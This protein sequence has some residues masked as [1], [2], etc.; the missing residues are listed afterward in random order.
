MLQWPRVDQ[1]RSHCIECSRVFRNIQLTNGTCDECKKRMTETTKGALSRAS[2]GVEGQAVLASAKLLASIRAQGKNSKAMPKI[3]D[4]FMQAMGGEEGYSL[5]MQQQ[6]LKAHGEGLSDDEFATFEHDPKLI[7]AW[8]EMI[9]R[10][11]SKADEGMN[12]DLSSLEESDLEEILYDIGRKTVLDDRELR[13]LCLLKAIDADSEFR[14]EAFIA[15]CKSEPELLTAEL[16][17]E[18][19]VTVSGEV[20]PTPE[21]EEEEDSLMFDEYKDE[22]D[23]HTD[24]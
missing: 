15:I 9:N 11:S 8:Y 23:T 6:F 22:G 24:T 13:R 12:V 4:A 3:L 18:G 7:L 17:K 5:R 2:R 1:N 20:K 16:E 21:D 10:H 14:K 19:V